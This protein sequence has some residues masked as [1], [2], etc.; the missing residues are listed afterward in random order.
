[1]SGSVRNSKKDL[2][3]HLIANYSEKSYFLSLGNVSAIY[4]RG[5]ERWC[6]E[7]VTW[8]LIPNTNSFSF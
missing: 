6:Q 2:K 7:H 1:M 8:E 3:C 4:Y 5:F